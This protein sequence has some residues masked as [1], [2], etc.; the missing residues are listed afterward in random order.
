[1]VPKRF[2]YQMML[3]LFTSNM[4]GVTSETGTTLPLV[5]ALPHLAIVPIEGAV[6]FELPKG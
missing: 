6:L 2:P 1:M 5:A 4:M 3:V